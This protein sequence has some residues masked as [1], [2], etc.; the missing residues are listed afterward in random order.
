MKRKTLITGGTGLV[1]SHVLLDLLSTGESEVY[2]TRR[3]QSDLSSLQKLF[4]WERSSHLLNQINW[5]NWDLSSE[6]PSELPDQLD[7]IIHTAAVVSFDPN[8]YSAMDRINITATEELIAFA[9]RIDVQKFGFISSIAALGRV[10]EG[11]KYTEQSEWTKNDTNSYYSETKYLSEK[12][13]MA[14]HS[15]K[16]SCFVVNPGVVLGRCNWNKSS[17]TIFRTG[18]KGLSFYTKGKNG[19][20]DVRDVSCALLEIMR[21]GLS[22]E[23]HILVGENIEYR[24]VFDQIA[25]HFGKKPSKVYSPPWLTGIGWR[26]DKLISS[27]KGKSPTLTKET[28]SNANGVHIYDNSKMVNLGFKF[29]PLSQTIEDS[30]PFYKKYYF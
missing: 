22:N 25:T 4:E 27:I 28:A 5:V 7:E 9:K 19:F 23:K 20:V 8:D 26:L 15:D 11:E 14:A 1:G 18:A 6:L 2:A 24:S 10:K 12:I 17:G 30:I 29:I 13:V 21:R 3:E 16:M